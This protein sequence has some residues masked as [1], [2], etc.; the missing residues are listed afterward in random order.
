MIFGQGAIFEAG[1]AG[2]DPVLFETG[3][4]P[5]AYTKYEEFSCAVDETPLNTYI[6]FDMATNFSGPFYCVLVFD[7][8]DLGLDVTDYTDVRVRCFTDSAVPSGGQLKIVV[9][10]STNDTTE[11]AKANESVIT[12]NAGQNITY[13][14]RDL[15]IDG[16][17]NY[18]TAG[19]DHLWVGFTYGLSGFS[20]PAAMDARYYNIE[21][22]P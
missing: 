6:D 22:R 2:G 3:T 1:N 11:P 20:V 9:G 8:D 18:G 4:A 17:T 5:Q 13:I 16:F 19:Y 15:A 14:F 7:L 12:F 10:L 21:L